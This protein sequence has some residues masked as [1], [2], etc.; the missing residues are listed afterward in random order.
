MKCGGMKYKTG[1]STMKTTVGSATPKG[2]IYGI[3]QTGST[4]PNIKGIDT[5]K[6]GGPVKK[7]LVKAQKGAFV[8]Y[9][10]KIGPSSGTSTSPIA[11]KGGAVK[12]TVVKKKK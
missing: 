1:G 9:G 4:G 3:P 11:K 5:A 2:Q 8:P 12:K 10:E 6:N 7:K